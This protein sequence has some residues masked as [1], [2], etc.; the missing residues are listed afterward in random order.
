[1]SGLGDVDNIVHNI[2]TIP[3]DVQRVAEKKKKKKKTS[4][5]FESI[6]LFI[7]LLIED[8]LKWLKLIQI[9]INCKKP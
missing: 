5:H 1:M 9:Y 6:F 2:N 8:L 7:C 3:S 4:L